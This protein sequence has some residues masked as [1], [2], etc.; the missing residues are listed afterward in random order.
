MN[1]RQQKYK[2][3]RILGM[4]Q[5]NAAIAAGYSAGYARARG[6]EIEERA[7]IA[8]V[9]ERQGLT[10][11][12]LIIKL[13]ELIDASDYIFKKDKEGKSEIIGELKLYSPSWTARSK[14]LELAL[15]LKDLLKDKVEH[16]GQVK[17]GETKIILITPSERKQTAEASRIEV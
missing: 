14:G 12:I 2:K 7:N 3:N 5:Y 11:K 4:N 17:T 6:K 1:I 10:D 16:S 8:D 15:K 9:L 13:A